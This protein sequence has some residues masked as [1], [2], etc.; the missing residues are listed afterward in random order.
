MA[1]NGLKL[2]QLQTAKVPGSNT[3]SINENVLAGGQHRWCRRSRSKSAAT[4]QANLIT[5]KKA[6]QQNV[7]A[8][9]PERGVRQPVAVPGTVSGQRSHHQRASTMF[10]TLL[11][12]R[13]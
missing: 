11:G 4:A 8:R 5:Q 1:E 10:D 12:L 6:A 13:G 2:A 3:T 7:S 9:E